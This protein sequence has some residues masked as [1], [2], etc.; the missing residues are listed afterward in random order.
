MTGQ[1]MP[2][3][4]MTCAVHTPCMLPREYTSKPLRWDG[5]DDL[6][7]PVGCFLGCDSAC[8]LPLLQPLLTC[9]LLK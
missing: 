3:Y 5:A 9:M 4:I 2:A 6:V 8:M 1:L 7:Q